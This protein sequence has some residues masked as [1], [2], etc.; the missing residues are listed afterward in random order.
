MKL[1][2]KDRLGCNKMGRDK[3]KRLG[4]FSAREKAKDNIGPM[5][6]T[7][8]IVQSQGRKRKWAEDFDEMTEPIIGRDQV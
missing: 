3:I 6:P 8:S 4:E 7:P 1:I 2:E 5:P